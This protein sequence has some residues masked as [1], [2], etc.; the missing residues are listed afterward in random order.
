MCRYNSFLTSYFLL[1]VFISDKTMRMQTTTTPTPPSDVIHLIK[2]HV[3]YV[4]LQ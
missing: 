3:I 1:F 2:E 4:N